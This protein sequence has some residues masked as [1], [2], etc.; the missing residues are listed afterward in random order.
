MTAHGRSLTEH[1]SL[2]VAL[3]AH[4]VLLAVLSLGLRSITPPPLADDPIPVELVTA[5][6]V[7]NALTPPE[8]SIK[9]APQ[10]TA[11]VAPPEPTPPTPEPTAVPVPVPEPDPLPVPKPK[12]AEP[13]EKPKPEKVK[14]ERV[15]PDK[16]VEKPTPPKPEK[17]KPAPKLLDAAALSTLL[18]KSIPKAKVKP[19]DTL[20]LAKS[21]EKSLPKAAVATTARADPRAAAAIAAAIRAQVYP[22]WSPPFGGGAGKVT[23]LLR[24]EINRDGSISGRP[25]IVSQTGVT[26]SNGDYA[27]AFAETAR[28]AVLRC[29]PLKLPPDSYDQWK[30]VEINFDPVDLG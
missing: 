22:C 23:A 21:I 15:K 25:A 20:A 8:P 10:E 16:L 14:P 1:Q 17:V 7:S 6:D 24:L 3:A 12:K 2:A 4:L 11:E 28:R 30:A 26:A 13:V 19:L 9:A 5:A 27:R 18:D 29:S